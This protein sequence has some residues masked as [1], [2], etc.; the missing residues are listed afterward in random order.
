METMAALITSIGT[1]LTGMLAWASDVI[2]F[3]GANPIILFPILVG[4][5]FVGVR[6]VKSMVRGV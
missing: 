2:T 5:S 1:I 3:V 4:F 6:I